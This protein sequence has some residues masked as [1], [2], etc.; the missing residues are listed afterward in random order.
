MGALHHPSPYSPPNTNDEHAF[1]DQLNGLGIDDNHD[2]LVLAPSGAPP[3]SVAHTNLGRRS[4]DGSSSVHLCPRHSKG[5]SHYDTNGMSRATG[6]LC[7]SEGGADAIDDL[8]SKCLILMQSLL[9]EDE[10]TVFLKGCHVMTQMSK[11]IG[12]LCSSE[13]GADAIDDLYSKCLILMQSLLGKDEHAVFL[14]G[15]HVTIQM[16]RA[17][18][19]L[20]SSEGGAMP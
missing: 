5:K 1:E 2:P 13:G 20:C 4:T 19:L 18:G 7:S 6:L 10:H 9:G 14:K 11:A 15:C 17:T 8:Y 12:L 16:S 3:P